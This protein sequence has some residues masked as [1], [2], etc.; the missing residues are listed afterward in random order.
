MMTG[1]Q[2]PEGSVK[3]AFWDYI[4]RAKREG[5]D[6]AAAYEWA[7]TED[8]YSADG[9]PIDKSQATADGMC[10]HPQCAAINP[11]KDD[12]SFGTRLCS[13]CGLVLSPHWV[14]VGTDKERCVCSGV[15]C[16]IPTRRELAARVLGC[17]YPIGF[18]MDYIFGNEDPNEP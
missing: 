12:S 4:N 11:S 3:V 17:S 6:D 14:D 8:L 18:A 2:S 5:L 13:I 9:I 1:K 7:I 15:P 16:K 10:Y